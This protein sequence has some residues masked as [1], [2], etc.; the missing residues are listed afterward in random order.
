MEEN[1]H[2]F[3]MLDQI[4]QPGFFVRDDR[5]IRTN[6]GASAMLLAEGQSF[7]GLLATGQSAYA[8]FNEGMLCL[9]L[10]IAEKQHSAVVT[11]VEDAHLVL[12]EPEEELEEFRAMAL[13]SMQMRTPLMQAISGARQL[14]EENPDPAAARLNRSLMQMLR[15]VSNMAD[16]SRY[17]ASAR[18]ESRDVDAL[19]LELF[20]KA[21]VLAENQVRVSF[22]GLK[23]PV[24]SLI[25]PEQLERAVWNLLSNC[26]KFT[27]EGGTI[28]ATLTRQGKQLRLTLEDSGSGIADAVRSTLFQRYLRQPGIED[29]RHGLGLGLAIVRAAA[30]NHGGTVLISPVRTGGTRITM[31][32]SIRQ[33][34]DTV[35]R[36]PLFR[37]DYIG[38]WDHGLVELSDCIGTQWYKTL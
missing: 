6:R 38:G 1:K 10:S 7:S 8:D 21:G 37:P 15:M 17:A 11:T 19:L 29:S 9:T 20:E 33:S 27:P 3:D 35:L 22:E 34:D 25:D 13:V 32:L 5:I 14:T 16:I 4:L 36:S 26:I 30:A 28:N 31:T 23:Q 12:L 24:F 18:M 2:Y